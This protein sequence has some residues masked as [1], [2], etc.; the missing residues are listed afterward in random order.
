[1]SRLLSNLKWNGYWIDPISV[2]SMPTKTP[3]TLKPVVIDIN[4]QYPPKETF[5][6]ISD[7]SKNPVWQNG[8]QE[9]TITTE[10]PLAVGTKYDQKARFMG[11]D[12]ISK[13]EVIEFEAGRKVKA[14]T[15]ESSFPITFTRMVD[16]NGEGSRVR[17][18][19]EGDPKGFFKLMGFL[20]QKKAAKTIQKDYEKLKEILEYKS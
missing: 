9:C 2:I 10:G 20:L 3:I 13:F 17:A 5:D 7:F 12:V 11:K 14:T 8:M 6:F 15:Y 16:P 4:I 19:I 18:I 1:M